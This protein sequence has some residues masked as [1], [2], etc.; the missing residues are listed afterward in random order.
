MFSVRFGAFVDSARL[1]LD[2]TWLGFIFTRLAFSSLVGLSVLSRVPLTF[3]SVHKYWRLFDGN[4][5]Q[6]ALTEFF[7]ALQ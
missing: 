3:S 7:I 1:R 2:S 4:R 5:S 6:A